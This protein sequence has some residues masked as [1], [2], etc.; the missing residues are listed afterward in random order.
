[1]KYIITEVYYGKHGGIVFNPALDV[2]IF[3]NYVS[4][5]RYLVHERRL[6]KRCEYKVS[7]EWNPSPQ[8]FGREWFVSMIEGHDIGHSIFT[9]ARIN[10]NGFH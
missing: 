2:E 10:E 8:K 9:V 1:M 7:L 6:A 4:A 5:L 3:D